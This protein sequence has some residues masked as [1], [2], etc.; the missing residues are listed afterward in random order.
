[1]KSEVKGMRGKEGGK[2]GE[3]KEGRRKL[4]KKWRSWRKKVV[5]IVRWEI[6][7]SDGEGIWMELRLSAQIIVKRRE[8]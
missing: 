3:K 8:K 2:R 5:E 7:V 6:E 1:M 4:E